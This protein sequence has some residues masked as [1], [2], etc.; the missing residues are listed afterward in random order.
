MH[1]ESIRTRVSLRDRFRGEKEFVGG[2]YFD[3][4]ACLVKDLL[5]RRN[6]KG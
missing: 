2:H 4:K 1:V 5:L 3:T 6:G